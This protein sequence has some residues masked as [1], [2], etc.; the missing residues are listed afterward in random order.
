MIPS[1][2]HNRMHVDCSRMSNIIQGI[3]SVSVTWL[4]LY[5]LGE[6]ILVSVYRIDF[7][8]SGAS[9][10]ADQEVTRFCVILTNSQ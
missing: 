1:V 8:G 9:L 3:S 2:F 4:N 10:K 6:I 7:I 5:I